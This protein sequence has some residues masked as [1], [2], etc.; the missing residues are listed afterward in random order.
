MTVDNGIVANEAVAVAN[1]LGIDVI[2]T[3]HH[4]LGKKVPKALAI[5]HTAEISGAGAA[6][7]MI[8]ELGVEMGL[9]L[10]AIGTVAD[11]MTLLGANRSIVKW[12]LT[13]LNRTGRLGLLAMYDKAGVSLGE[14]G[15]REI[16]YVIAPRI[17]ASG[18]LGSAMD[19]LRLLCT[20]KGDRAGEIAEALQ[21]VNSERQKLVEESVARAVG[22]VGGEM[23]EGIL[24]IAHEEYHE[25]TIG[26]IASALVEKY[27]RPAVVF[28]KGRRISKAS[29]RSISGFNIIETVRELEK[30]LVAGGGH[31]MAAG[32]SVRTDQLAEFTEK[33]VAI[34]KPILTEDVLKKSLRIDLEI[35]F[36]LIDWKLVE[37][38][39]DFSPF[40]L[41]NPRPV[42]CT[43]G[44]EIKEVVTV[45]EGGKH[46]KMTLRNEGREYG[47]IAFGMGEMMNE[48][49]NGE[50]VDVA[51]SV[52]KNVW[53]GRENLQL[54][55]RDI[56]TIS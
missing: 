35:G 50:K 30:Y 51:Y 8:R 47:A 52:E 49:E 24:V 14:I 4:S 22:Q 1:K 7:V 5:V 11:Q 16:N 53:N 48:I 6:W 2:V 34:S 45:G 32:F 3:D 26:L 46:L 55:V 27:Y 21:K 37:R 33:L 40:G 31:P 29:A 23:S 13:N 19:S 56:K 12:G 42:F 41:G 39:E 25:G 20:K 44:V 18:R 54:K 43:R 36:S 10:P 38:I 28:S 9:E 15:M 17:N